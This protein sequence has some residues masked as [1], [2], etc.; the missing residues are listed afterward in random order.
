MFLGSYTLTGSAFVAGDVEV[1]GEIDSTD[2]LRLKSA[3]M[4]TYEL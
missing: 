3:F 1:S 2:Y 4:G